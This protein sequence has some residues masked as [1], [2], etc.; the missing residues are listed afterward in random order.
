M[1]ASSDNLDLVSSD[2]NKEERILY[3]VVVHLPEW[4]PD[5]LVDENFDSFYEVDE[6]KYLKQLQMQ[7]S[8]LFTNPKKIKKGV[9]NVFK[10]WC[11]R[12]DTKKIETNLNIKKSPTKIKEKKSS[13]FLSPP[14]LKDKTKYSTIKKKVIIILII[15]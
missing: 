13:I 1:S 4:L 5:T 15:V 12:N 14:M 9:L 3:D 11:R 2:D 8:L 10:E 6:A 7:H